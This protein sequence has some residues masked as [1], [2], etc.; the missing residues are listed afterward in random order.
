MTTTI[1]K[2]PRSLRATPKPTIWSSE[3]R[4]PVPKRG[5]EEWR[6]HMTWNRP[7]C[8]ECSTP[9]CEGEVESNEWGNGSGEIDPATGEEDPGFYCRDCTRQMGVCSKCGGELSPD[10]GAKCPQCGWVRY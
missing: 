7:D 1:T 4:S 6:A 10:D 3:P 5:T 2:K 9:E 8:T